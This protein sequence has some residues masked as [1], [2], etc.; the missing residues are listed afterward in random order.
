MGDAYM[1]PVIGGTGLLY[2]TYVSLGAS[3]LA[4]FSLAAPFAVSYTISLVVVAAVTAL[5]QRLLQSLIGGHV[6]TIMYSYNAQT[7]VSRLTRRAA[8]IAPSTRRMWD[9]PSASAQMLAFAA[10]FW[11]AYL[12]DEDNADADAGEP[13]PL[14]HA[15]A[16]WGI[17]ALV[18]IYA[19]TRHLATLEQVTLGIAGGAL[20][21]A[22]LYNLAQSFAS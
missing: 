2:A 10:A 20:L 21:G 11:T 19:V 15:K 22:Q 7:G 1:P 3:A 13:P 14:W 6:S 9:M 4:A 18:C 12:G 5:E 8:G 16:L 17:L